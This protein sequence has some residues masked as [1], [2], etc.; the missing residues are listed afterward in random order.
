M[1]SCSSHC[2][3]IKEYNSAAESK[4]VT[5]DRFPLKSG[6]VQCFLTAPKV[7][8]Q[9]T[10]LKSL[11]TL[12]SNPEPASALHKGGESV[13]YSPV[14]L[15]QGGQNFYHRIQV[16]WTTTKITPLNKRN[17]LEGLRRAIQFITA[18]RN[19]GSDDISHKVKY[20]IGQFF[21]SGGKWNKGKDA[22]VSQWD[23]IN[24]CTFIFAHFHLEIHWWGLLWPISY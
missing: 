21:L 2:W 5:S 14:N 11:K 19:S 18:L 17:S 8:F 23:K 12:L 15:N 24:N 6:L 20:S 16:L 22:D 1:F 7:T 10:E 13:C 4:V 3:E 9:T